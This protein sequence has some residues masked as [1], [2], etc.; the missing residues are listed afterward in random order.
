MANDKRSNVTQLHTEAE[1][2]ESA[3]AA[4]SAIPADGKD[5]AS[6]WLDPGLVDDIADAHIHSV[7]IGK[8][9]DYFRT[10]P[11]DWRR[12]CEMYVHKV[13]NVIG[14]QYFIIAP[15]MRG[16]IDEARPVTLVVV[17][18]REGQ[19]RLWPIPAPREGETDN[20]SWIS[21]RSAA[22]EGIDR[23]IKLKWRAPAYYTRD[24]QPGYAPDPDFSKLPPFDDLIRVA[25]G[26]AGIIRDEDHFMFREVMGAPKAK[27]DDLDADDL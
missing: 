17:V 3:P 20:A 4:A 8:P 24:A 18:N 12:R 1:Q 16:R 26:E 22:R 14:E 19:P 15:S 6:L 10:A 25:L 5:I 21:Q 27:P 2:P 9:R 13:E 11:A 23:W 7:P